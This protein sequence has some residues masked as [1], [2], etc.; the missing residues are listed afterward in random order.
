[1]T[2]DSSTRILDVAERLVQERGY[3]GFSYADV[4]AELGVTKASLHYH[5]PSK[6][7]LGT[8]LIQRYTERFTDSL[9]EIEMRST[10]AATR[11]DAYAQLY[12]DVLGGRGMC[13]CG[14]LAAEYQTL[15]GSMREAVVTFLDDNENWLERILELGR[16]NDGLRFEGSARDAARF[17]LSGLEGA[18][19]LARPYDDVGRFRSAASRLL[20]GLTGVTPARRTRAPARPPDR[21]FRQL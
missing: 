17:L 8:A 19:L 21:A 20:T 16:T 14:M 3:N 6:A 2:P 12:A 18:M 15:P 5:F 1:M 7:Q 10:L 11:L 9:A 4:A 13:L